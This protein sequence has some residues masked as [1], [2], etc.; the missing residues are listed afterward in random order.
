LYGAAGSQN[1]PQIQTKEN[2]V[3]NTCLKFDGYD[4]RIGIAYSN[5][6]NFTSIMSVFSWVKGGAQ[7]SEPE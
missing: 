6:I 7:G 1:L 2:C 5:N 3:Y 4:D